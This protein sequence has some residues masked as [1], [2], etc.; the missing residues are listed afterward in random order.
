MQTHDNWILSLLHCCFVNWSFK[1]TVI[2]ILAYYVHHTIKTIGYNNKNLR[3]LLV[4]INPFWIRISDTYSVELITNR[5]DASFHLTVYC[6]HCTI[7][8]KIKCSRSFTS[9]WHGIAQAFNSNWQKTVH[10]YTMP[11]GT[12]SLIYL[13]CFLQKST[14]RIFFN[15]FHFLSSTFWHTK[16]SK[17][18]SIHDIRT[19]LHKK[20]NC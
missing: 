12:H 3:Y 11:N 2:S 16:Q 8:P 17:T 14:D 13:D 6:V 1:H 9:K 15:G 19:N 18:H 5:L 7:Q 20:T 4:S 10:I